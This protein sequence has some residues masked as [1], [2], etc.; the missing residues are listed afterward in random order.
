V[1]CCSCNRSILTTYQVSEFMF[2][3]PSFPHLRGLELAVKYKELLITLLPG[4]PYSKWKL[5]PGYDANH[6]Y[7]PQPKH[8]VNGEFVRQNDP[9]ST[10]TSAISLGEGKVVRRPGTF[11]EVY[12][13]DPDYLRFA[14]AQGLPWLTP[15]DQ[16]QSSPGTT[17]FPDRSCFNGQA[18]GAI[19]G[20]TPPSSDKSKSIN[21]GSSHRGSLSEAAGL[22]PQLPNGVQGV[23]ESTAESK[24]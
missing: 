7:A 4:K 12:T 10:K 23:G 15:G 3:V 5:D 22:S 24:S 8:Y 1:Y 20:I 13:D 17:M 16:P 19:S 11:L 21:G 18:N 6:P 9:P 2:V 14:K